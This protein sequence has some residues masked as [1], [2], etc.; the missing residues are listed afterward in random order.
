MLII[1]GI[2]VAIVVFSPNDVLTRY[3]MVAS[4]VATVAGWFPAVKSLQRVSDF[5]E[6]SGLYFSVMFFV[7]PLVLVCAFRARESVVR[8]MTGAWVRKSVGQWFLVVLLCAIWLTMP[9][10][11]YVWNDGRDELFR[12]LPMR[13]SKLVLAILG[14]CAAGGLAWAGVSY[15]MFIFIYVVRNVVKIKSRG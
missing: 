9:F 12:F 5:P 2:S 10:S 11:S 15:A 14:W 7:T 6:V 8:G 3:P 13:S 4:F 1:Q